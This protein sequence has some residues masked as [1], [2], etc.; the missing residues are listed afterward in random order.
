MFVL[1]ALLIATGSTFV[2]AWGVMLLVGI[3]HHDWWP[4][5]PTMSYN[6]ALLICFVLVAFAAVKYLLGGL[7]SAASE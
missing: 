5:I 3:A 4:V 2:S 1:Y 7:I 6:T